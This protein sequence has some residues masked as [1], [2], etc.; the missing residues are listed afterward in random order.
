MQRNLIALFSVSYSR[1]HGLGDILSCDSHMVQGHAPEP[2]PGVDG[3][4]LR[5]AK[6]LW[7]GLH[8]SEQPLEFAIQASSHASYSEC[9]VC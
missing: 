8:Q 2:E 7:A 9:L 6:E 5:A 3:D 1:L 4:T